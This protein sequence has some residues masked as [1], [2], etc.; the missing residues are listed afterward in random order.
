[1]CHLVTQSFVE[2][3]FKFEI[4]VDVRVY[5]QGQKLDKIDQRKKYEYNFRKYEPSAGD[6][7]NFFE[8]LTLFGL[9]ALSM[10]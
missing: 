1:M 4:G 10:F 7:F 3:F 9:L 6:P 5:V 2:R 8:V